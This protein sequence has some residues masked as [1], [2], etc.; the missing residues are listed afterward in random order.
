MRKFKI[1]LAIVILGFIAM[2]VAQNELYF[3]ATNSF[4][5]KI[6]MMEEYQSPMVS[7]WQVGLGAFVIGGL[8]FFLASLPGRM[9]TRK[10]LKELNATIQ[11]HQDKISSLTSQ[12]QPLS[13]SQPPVAPAA[14]RDEPSAKENAAVS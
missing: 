5:I 6:P 14:D 12:R 7:N 8:L 10:T 13:E 3:K 4:R 9:R 1:I 11:T 2:F